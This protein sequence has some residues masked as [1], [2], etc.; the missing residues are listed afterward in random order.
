MTAA[1]MK[2]IQ[3]RFDRLDASLGALSTRLSSVE[4]KLNALQAAVAA[5]EVE[6]TGFATAAALEEVR[7]LASSAELIGMRIL[8]GETVARA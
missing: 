8:N 6:P 5:P 4:G 1:E 3:A 2:Q 7:K